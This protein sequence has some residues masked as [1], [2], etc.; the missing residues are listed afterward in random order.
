VKGLGEVL[1]LK[2]RKI[3]S[4]W[5]SEISARQCQA[6][7]GTRSVFEPYHTIRFLRSSARFGIWKDCGRYPGWQGKIKS[8]LLQI[9]LIRPKHPLLEHDHNSKQFCLLGPF[10]LLLLIGDILPLRG[11]HLVS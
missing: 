3:G 10:V 7:L 11:Q 9:N 2:L 6:V 8:H 4:E 5:L 1:Y